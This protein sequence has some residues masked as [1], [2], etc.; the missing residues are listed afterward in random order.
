MKTSFSLI[1]PRLIAVKLLAAYGKKNDLGRIKNLQV[2]THKGND[3]E[4]MIETEQL[5]I[6]KQNVEAWNKWR[7]ENPELKIELRNGNL[8][9]VNLIEAN[10]SQANLS[11]ANLSHANF[12]RASLVGA[13]LSQANLKGTYCSQ[14]NLERANLEGANLERAYLTATNLSTTQL[15]NTNLTKTNLTGACLHNCQINHRTNLDNIVGKYIYLKSQWDI[16]RQQDDFLE[17]RP[18]DPHRNFQP[19]ELESWLEKTRQT[20]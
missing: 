14:A 2:F 1:I 5:K 20:R 9:G 8:I 4:P 11:H 18:A 6:L 7:T 3:L 15:V 17:R 19:G 16:Q 12:I 13:N 10:L